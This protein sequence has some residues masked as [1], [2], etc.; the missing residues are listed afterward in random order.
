MPTGSLDIKVT[1]LA[2]ARVRG[3][4]LFEFTPHPG[5]SG[6]GGR[7]MHVEFV[8]PDTDFEISGIE[9]RGGLGTTYKVTVTTPHYRPYAFFQII[10]EGQVNTAADDVEFWVDH[11]AVK[12]IRGPAFADLPAEARR[13]LSEAGMTAEDTEDDDLLGL[14]GENLYSS[15]GSLRRA[16]FLNIVKK[17]GHERTTGNCLPLIGG[18]LLCRQDRFFA[19][20][21]DELPERLRQSPLFLSAPGALHKPLAGYALAEGSFK[22]RDAHANIQITFMQ[23]IQDGSLAADIDIDEASG[24]KHGLEVIRNRVKDERTHPAKIREFLLAADPV[25]RSLDPGYQVTF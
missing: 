3:P 14:S 7:I 19:R 24:F 16:C 2:G 8:T 13:C 4:V 5:N 11:H 15:L 10:K 6:A 22:S 20:V 17:A 23:H 9:C 1:D 21:A 12:G 18:L 25:D